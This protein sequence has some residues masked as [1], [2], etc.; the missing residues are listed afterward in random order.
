[1]MNFVNDDAL[2]M[3]KEADQRPAGGRRDLKRDVVD[4]CILI[5]ARVGHKPQKQG[6]A[7]VC[8]GNGNVIHGEKVE[9][10]RQ[11]IIGW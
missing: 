8:R 6:L 2:F 9:I 4:R 5:Q 10:S 1:M 3:L 7:N 11:G